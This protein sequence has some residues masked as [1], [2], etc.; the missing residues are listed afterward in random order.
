[1]SYCEH[2]AQL[3]RTIG[4][5]I[6]SY[7][8]EL[9]HDQLKGKLLS[10]LIS[11]RAISAAL[12]VALP[13]AL[14][15]PALAIVP[16]PPG[17]GAKGKT[18]KSSCAWSVAGEQPRVGQ[19]YVSMKFQPDKNGSIYPT[20]WT[21]RD[22]SVGLPMDE[23]VFTGILNRTDGSVELF[24]GVMGDRETKSG[25]PTAVR[26]Y[27]GEKIT[28]TMTVQDGDWYPDPFGFPTCTGTIKVPS[29]PKK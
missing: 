5:S 26:V 29:M 10:R 27:P 24:T 7:L 11:A 1:M 9:L 3:P 14:A 13:V 22:D 20:K 6:T 12:C 25:S 4:R 8:V 19:A 28:Y 17:G 15:A 21:V 18:V 23:I 16:K 2:T